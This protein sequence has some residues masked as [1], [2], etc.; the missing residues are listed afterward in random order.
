MG[1]TQPP[2]QWVA[3]YYI[4]SKE[5]RAYCRGEEYHTTTPPTCLHEMDRNSFTST[6]PTGSVKEEFSLVL[7]PPPPPPPPP[8]IYIYILPIAVIGSL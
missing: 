7:S 8:Q 2:V 5:P 3:G 1:Y 4:G 6:L